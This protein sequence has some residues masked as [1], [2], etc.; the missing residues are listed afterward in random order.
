LWSE[1]WLKQKKLTANGETKKSY[2]I[3]T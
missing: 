1:N 3:C 2:Y